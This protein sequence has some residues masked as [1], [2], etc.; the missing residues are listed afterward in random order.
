MAVNADYTQ[1]RFSPCVDKKCSFTIARQLENQVR[2]VSIKGI[3]GSIGNDIDITM[4]PELSLM[5]VG[6]RSTIKNIDVKAFSINKATNA[7]VNKEQK[8]VKLPTKNDLVVA[9]S[10]WNAVDLNVETVSF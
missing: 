9:I 1:I 2:A 5:R 4:S 6:N 10:D 3:G 7:P 8:G